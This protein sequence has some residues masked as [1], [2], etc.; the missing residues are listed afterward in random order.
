MKGAAELTQLPRSILFA[1]MLNQHTK[2]LISARKSSKTLCEKAKF[3]NLIRGL[4]V[5]GPKD[6]GQTTVQVTVMASQTKIEQNFPM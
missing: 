5:V 4:A 1:K 6:F 2:E 3:M